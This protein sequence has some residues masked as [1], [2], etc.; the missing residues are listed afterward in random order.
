MRSI[1]CPN[2]HTKI[3]IDES[4]YNAILRQVRT[5]EF[6]AEV[7]A[8]VD[9]FKS[10]LETKF[11]MAEIEYKNKLHNLKLENERALEKAVSDKKLEIESMNYKLLNSKSELDTQRQTFENMLKLKDEQIEYYKD[12]KAKQSTK[13]V[14][15]SLEQYCWNEFNKHRAGAFPTAYFEKDNEVSKSGS[16]GDFIFRDVIDNIE[17][18]SI[19]FEMK[20]ESDTTVSKHKNED[21]F[22][23]LD[24]DR[25][26]KGC[27]YAVLVSML[28]SDNEFYNQGIADV[29]YRYDKMYV[30]RPQFFISF[31]TMLRNASMASIGV[32][33][34]LVKVQQENFDVVKFMDNL[35]EFKTKFGRNYNL[36]EQ[37]FNDAITNIDKTIDYLQ[38]VRDALTVSTKHLSAANKQAQDLSIKKLTKDNP[39]M[40][41]KFKK[42]GCDL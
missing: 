8:R 9:L 22:K 27:E 1:I 17:Y 20:N 29:S 6:D 16:K 15:E 37:R 41:D 30:I 11:N 39:T 33:K 28:E 38:K 7:N 2:C 36:A 42:G 14:G 13:M 10:E 4:D 23:E 32:R 19:M 18:L 25:R 35:E 12:F 40:T 5:E 24:K 26:E 21:F 31:I 34:E 3:D